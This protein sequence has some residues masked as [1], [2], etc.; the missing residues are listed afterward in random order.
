MDPQISLGRTQPLEVLRQQAMARTR[1]FAWLL[2]GFAGVGLL[3][4][5]VGLYGVLAQLARGRAR[6]MGIRIALG[7][8]P[9]QVQWIVARHAAAIVG[10]GMIAGSAA[11]LMTTRVMASLLFGVAPN[12]P[13]V[14]AVAT[15]V[16]AVTGVFAAYIP[17]W[18]A[19]MVDPMQVLRSD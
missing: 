5:A 1:F 15:G 8:R 19:S 11:A 18:R 4:G 6:E 3:L 7:A 16:L 12:D 2:F 13:L 9:V 14:F 17:A 10:I